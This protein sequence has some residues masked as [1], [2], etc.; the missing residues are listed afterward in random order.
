MFWFLAAFLN[1]HG[2]EVLANL[3]FAD[4]LEA[5]LKGQLKVSICVEI[6]FK[7]TVAQNGSTG[8]KATLKPTTGLTG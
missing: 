2:A 4:S 7:R 8:N 6:R 3:V 5:K 1:L